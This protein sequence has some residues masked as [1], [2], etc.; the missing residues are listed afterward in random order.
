LE[1]LAALYNTTVTAIENYNPDN[2][3]V[4]NF[5][6]QSKGIFNAEKV[7]LSSIEESVQKILHE[8]GLEKGKKITVTISFELQ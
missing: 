2:P 4:N 5:Y 3:M 6:D 7:I 1:K 8:N